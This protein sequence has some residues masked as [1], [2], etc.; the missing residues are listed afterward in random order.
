[1][2]REKQDA[3]LRFGRATIEG[4][5]FFKTQKAPTIAVLKKYAKTDLTTLDN[6]YAYLRTALPDAPYPT[7]DGM[8]TLVAEV[9]RTQPAALKTD[10][11]SFVDASIV[12]A[13]EDEGFLKRLSKY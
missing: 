5:H 2:L 1:M 13:L 12:K 9:G 8:K 10:P 3:M 7:L 4:I 11:A 6:T